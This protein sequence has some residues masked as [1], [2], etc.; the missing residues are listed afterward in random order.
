MK[1]PDSLSHILTVPLLSQELERSEQMLVD[2]SVFRVKKIQFKIIASIVL[3]DPCP[4][5]T[6]ESGSA[7]RCMYD[8]A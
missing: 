5:V 6:L 8:L 1:V 2:C 3:G 7:V 4:A